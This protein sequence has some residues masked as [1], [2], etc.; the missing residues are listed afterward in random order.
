MQFEKSENKKPSLIKSVIEESKR[1]RAER[2]EDFYSEKKP[3]GVGAEFT[4]AKETTKIHNSEKQQKV[5]LNLYA[6]L[7]LNSLI[8]L[9]RMIKKFLNKKIRY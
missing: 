6:I 9:S 8:L 1:L 5:I 4:T 7:T 3:I 2:G